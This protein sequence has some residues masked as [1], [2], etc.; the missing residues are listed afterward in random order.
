MLRTLSRRMPLK[1]KISMT[2]PLSTASPSVLEA[3]EDDVL[4]QS[5]NSVRKITLNRPKKLNSLDLSMIKK[6]HPRLDAYAKSDEAKMILLN[7]NGRAFCAGGDVASL[8]KACREGHYEIGKQYFAAEYRLDHTVATFNKP[9]IAI[10]DGITMGGGVGLSINAPIRVVT[11]NTM[12]AM[13]ET[14]IGFFPDVGASRFLSALGPLGRYLAM[15]SARLTGADVVLAGLGTHY[16]PSER[17]GLLE[18]RLSELSTSSLD[19]IKG[20]IEEFTD[21]LPREFSLKRYQKVLDAFLGN[22]IPGIMKNLHAVAEN[23]SAEDRHFASETLK[24]MR[25]KSPISMAVA[26]QAQIDG[27]NWGVSQVFEKEYNIACVFMHNP[28]FVEGVEATLIK[29]GLGDWKEKDFG[30]DVD[31][32]FRGN[33]KLL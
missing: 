9:I 24:T 2:S 33:A 18:R 28:D 21:P 5:L 4:F 8:A 17:L 31:A 20:A 16:V 15:T 30:V 27:K 19:S 22:S 7:G 23:G 13:P 11:Q 32:Y 10:M 1:S 14:T 25:Q 29:K 6:I 12:F 26:L 3:T